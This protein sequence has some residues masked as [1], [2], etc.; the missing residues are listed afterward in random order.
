M[1]VAVGYM[2]IFS[3]YGLFFFFVCV[4][5]NHNIYTVYFMCKSPILIYGVCVRP[6]S[7][8]IYYTC[9]LR[10]RSNPLSLYF[11]TLFGVC[12]KMA[13]FRIV[14]ME[15]VYVQNPGIVPESDF[16]FVCVRIKS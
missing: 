2:C 7:Q 16:F 3:V 5:Y 10:V 12:V 14:S 13:I 8:N 9:V 4:A 11:A 1:R 6:K 15:C